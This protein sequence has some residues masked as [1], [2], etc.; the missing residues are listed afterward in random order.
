MTAI[1]V[2]QPPRIDGRLDDAC[3]KLAGPASGFIQMDPDEGEPATE[4]TSFRVAY[5]QD[6]LY[7]GIECL[8]SRPD[9]IVARLVPRDSNFWPGDVVGIVLDTFGDHQN[10]YG[11]AVNPRECRG[12]TAPRQMA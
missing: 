2:P 3:W 7:I 12:I 1:R 6:N 10:C 8:D 9:K 11:F 5:D 4:Q